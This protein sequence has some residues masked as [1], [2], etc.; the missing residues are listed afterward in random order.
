MSKSADS[1][2]NYIALTDTA[3]IIRKKIKKAVTDSGT[4][5]KA[6]PDKPAITNLLNIFSEITEWPIPKIEKKFLGKSYVQFKQELAEN[7]IQYL[8]PIQ[9]KYFEILKDKTALIKIL[10]EGSKQVAPIAQKTLIQV[11]RAIGLYS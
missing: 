10:A 7:L 11:K 9:K 4:E 6:S 1:P 2:Y 3:E 5:I 8:T